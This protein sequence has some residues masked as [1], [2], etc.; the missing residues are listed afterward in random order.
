MEQRITSKVIDLNG[1]SFTIRKFDARTGSRILFKVMN[2][3]KPFLKDIGREVVDN[4]KKKDAEVDNTK[5]LEAFMNISDEDFIMI[6]DACLR[7]CFEQL[8]AGLTPVLDR[9]GNFG[10]IGLEDDTTTVL[11]LSIQALTF[12]LEDFFSEK[13]MSLLLPK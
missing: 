8:P 2:I 7:V 5:F 1:R 10:V 9:A 12:N 4:A 13:N 11:A 6:Q 3:F